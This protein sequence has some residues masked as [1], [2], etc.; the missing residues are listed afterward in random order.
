MTEG[1]D[2]EQYWIDLLIENSLMGMKETK[3]LS[4]LQSEAKSIKLIFPSE[5]IRTAVALLIIRW[6]TQQVFAQPP[7]YC[8][9][10][11]L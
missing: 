8:L 1:Y 6:E 4:M 9:Y 10:A 7:Q 11:H 3:L 5:D 2:A